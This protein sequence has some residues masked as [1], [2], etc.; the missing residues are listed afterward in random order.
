LAQALVNVARAAPAETESRRCCPTMRL[1]TLL[2][3]TTAVR[4][5]YLRSRFEA[6]AHRD[7]PMPA[8]PGADEEP[9]PPSLP[10]PPLN[11]TYCDG[12][13]VTCEIK[14]CRTLVLPGEYEINEG[15]EYE[16]KH[17]T[18][19]HVLCSAG[20]LPTRGTEANITCNNGTW[21]GIRMIDPVVIK[22]QQLNCESEEKV[23]LLKE[24][25]H[26]LDYTN[27]TLLDT[28]SRGFPWDDSNAAARKG[29]LKL[30]QDTA[31]KVIND[32]TMDIWPEVD[33][34]KY[35]IKQFVDNN[36]EPRGEPFTE[37]SCVNFANHTLYKYP[38]P[39]ASGPTAVYASSNVPPLRPDGRPAAW[40]RATSDWSCK[41][42]IQKTGTGWDFMNAKPVI[43]YRVGCFCESKLMLGCPMKWPMYK[44]FGF[45][46]LEQKDIAGSD[47][48]ALCWF[49]SDPVHP[50]WG[51]LGNVN[52]QPAYDPNQVLPGPAGL[53][54]GLAHV[55]APAVNS[56][57]LF[58][59][60]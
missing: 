52:T 54:D 2:G 9:P 37:A 25:M 14:K 26:Y 56:S 44:N 40:D 17:S 32:T 22:P 59:P 38:D 20:N 19:L 13:N 57:E 33:G 28:E 29:N 7:E 51:Y 3:V 21:E 42:A 41:Q 16:M 43:Y 50:E 30:T 39:P 11:L 31:V 10:P 27:Q 47:I 49:W 53:P 8:S 35:M 5:G 12:P 58:A 1:L 18:L 6:V 45:S 46:S 23:R 55:E 60:S 15:E 34:L 36:M 24:V 48:K 4:L